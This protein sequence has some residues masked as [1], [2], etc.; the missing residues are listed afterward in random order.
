MNREKRR[1][2]EHEAEL[3][4]RIALIREKNQQIEQRTKEIEEDRA[5]NE[6]SIAKSPKTPSQT[7]PAKVTTPDRNGNSN[8]NNNTRNNGQWSREWDKGKTPA[9]TWRE[10]VPSMDLKGRLAGQH[11]ANQHQHHHHHN[12][13]N[14]NTQNGGNAAGGGGGG[15]K[16]HNN[17]NNNN[18]GKGGGVKVSPRLEGRISFPDRETGGEVV[19]ARRRKD[20]GGKGANQKKEGGEQEGKKVM[21]RDRSI[22]DA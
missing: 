22:M 21:Q 4:R 6:D 9:E 2:E 5:R 10:N 13:N 16:R 1:S 20:G 15:G 11:G 7:A 14:N 12:T 17:N 18:H 3:D 8:N 19:G